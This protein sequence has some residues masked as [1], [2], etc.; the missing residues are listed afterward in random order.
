MP[1]TSIPWRRLNGAI[2]LVVASL[3]SA[4]QTIPTI[5]EHF[6]EELL[7]TTDVQFNTPP[8]IPESAELHVLS[9]EQQA[10]FLQY[11]HD[12]ARAKVPGFRRVANYLAILIEDF[13]YSTSTFSAEQTLSSKRGNCLS[14]AM[15]T[16]ALAQL[17]NVEVGYQLMN[18]DP[19][20][21]FQGTIVAKGVHVRTLLLNLNRLPEHG[22]TEIVPGIAIDFFPTQRERFIRNMT[23]GEYEAMYYRNIANEALSESD[24]NTAYWYARE[25]LQYDPQSSEALYTLA[26]VNR[27]A[28]HTGEAESIYLYALEHS[29]EKLT[30]LKNYRVLLLNTGRLKEAQRIEAQIQRMDD[31]SPFHWFQLATSTFSD[32]DYRSAVNYYKRALELAPYLHEAHLGLA[33]SYFELG[34]TKHSLESMVAAIENA[35]GLQDR[36]YYKSKL[37]S[38]KHGDL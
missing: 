11:F 9:K 32:G 29:Q 31:P 38:L 3:L 22:T 30:L 18:S 34:Y 23:R 8:P 19:V 7:S 1:N 28:G 6:S 15:M 10:E 14:L 27:R 36:R 35:G 13:E 17:A 12:P 4:C 20:F 25:S 16:T 37:A 33:K 26:I 21:N 24:L 2:V 5:D